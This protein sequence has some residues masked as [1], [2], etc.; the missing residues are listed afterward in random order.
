MLIVN[1]V[2]Q[3]RAFRFALYLTVKGSGLLLLLSPRHN[4]VQT[5]ARNPQV[6]LEHRVGET[7]VLNNSF[8]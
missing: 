2:K 6:G 7:P 3:G 4:K 1:H 5:S 8:T